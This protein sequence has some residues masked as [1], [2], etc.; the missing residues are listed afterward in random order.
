VEFK[1]SVR[2]P[3]VFHI[4]PKLERRSET[5]ELGTSVIFVAGL[6]LLGAG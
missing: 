6:Q 2:T 4:T 5:V 3:M 1:H